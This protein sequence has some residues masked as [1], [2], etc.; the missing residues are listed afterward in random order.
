MKT[1]LVGTQV[2]Q[3]NNRLTKLGYAGLSLRNMEL[4]SQ[5]SRAGLISDNMVGWWQSA[6]GV[7]Q[8]QNAVSSWLNLAPSRISLNK[9]LVQ[10]TAANM[11]TWLHYVASEGRYGYVNATIGNYFSTPTSAALSVVGNID[12]IA[13]VQ[14]D[15]WT[16]TATQRIASKWMSA[17][18]Q[19]SF[20]FT[21]NT[22]GTLLFEQSTLGSDTNTFTSTVST[23]FI[24]GTNHWIRV[25]FLA[26]NGAAGRTA[27][28]Y[29]STDGINWIQLG[30]EVVVAT[31]ANTFASTAPFEIGSFNTG[32]NPFGGRI[33]R[34]Q[35]YNGIQG[36]GGTLVFDFN[37]ATYVSGTMFLDSSANAAVIT[38]N[39]G[40]VVIYQSCLYFD[41]VNDFLT[42]GLFALGQPTT[43]Y[44]V[45]RQLTWTANDKLLDGNIIDSLDIFQRTSSPQIALFA[46]GV[47]GNVTWSLQSSDIITAVFN[48]TGSS[49]SINRN[50][51]TTGNV[52]TA[53]A[54]AISLGAGYAGGNAANITISELLVFNQTHSAG[55]QAIIQGYLN[56]K[57]SLGL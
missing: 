55:Q 26:D 30:A 1:F 51:P 8:S 38:L 15:D 28:F 57:Y 41:G 23:G 32:T 36:M 20:I 53:N 54:G 44:M 7:Q 2:K 11:P 17:G 35:V 48:S 46:G 45:A 6:M 19:R 56:E 3:I 49:L 25:S 37:P 21:V 52:G 50:A 16:P 13:M 14:M 4:M 12:I 9:N 10:G 40:S 31:A 47:V 27:R 42:T 43:I 22:N 34:L 39:G 5:L 24:D 18:G 33:Y 29:T